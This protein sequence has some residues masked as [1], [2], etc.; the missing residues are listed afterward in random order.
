MN[1]T[2][3]ISEFLREFVHSD[4]AYE[5]LLQI[6]S[7]SPEHSVDPL[8]FR[9]SGLRHGHGGQPMPPCEPAPAQG[10]HAAIIKHASQAMVHGDSVRGGSDRAILS[11]VAHIA[12]IAHHTQYR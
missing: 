9:C 10:T 7:L 3:D 11:R 1:R 8:Q 5:V 6:I 4:N 12:H 2:A